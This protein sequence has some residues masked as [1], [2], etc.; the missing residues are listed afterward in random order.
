MVSEQHMKQAEKI[1]A[2]QG[3]DVWHVLQ[4]RFGYTCDFCRHCGANIPPIPGEGT[5]DKCPKNEI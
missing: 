3:G 2:E 4:H 5:C 1:V